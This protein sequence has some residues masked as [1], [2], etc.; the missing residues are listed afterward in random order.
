MGGHSH[1]RVIPGM[2]GGQNSLFQALWPLIRPQFHF[3]PVS[4]DT[5]FLKFLFFNHIIGK[6]FE[7]RRS[8]SPFFAE[9]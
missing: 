7:F 8:K 1:E 4:E 5:S 9:F 3:A 6:F 2:S